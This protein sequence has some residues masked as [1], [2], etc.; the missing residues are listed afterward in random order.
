[1]QSG[2]K[3][4]RGLAML[5]R[6]QRHLDLSR[7]DLGTMLGLTGDAVRAWEE[8]SEEMPEIVLG[9]IIAAHTAL[10]QLLGVFLPE[11]LPLVIRRRAAAFDGERA[12]DWILDGRISEVAEKYDAGLSY[13]KRTA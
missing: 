3:H 2:E 11:R 4:D 5:G 8:R 1:M 13:L 9:R 10:D 6:I 7:E 12:L